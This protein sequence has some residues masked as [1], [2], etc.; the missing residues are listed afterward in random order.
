VDELLRNIDVDVIADSPAADNDRMVVA[1]TSSG[2]A[3]AMVLNNSRTAK[4]WGR[5]FELARA[6]AHLLLDQARGEAI[7]AASGPQ[8]IAGRRRRA[9]AFAAEMLL[10]TSALEEASRGVLDGVVEGHRFSELLDRF[11]VGR[12]RRLSISGTRDS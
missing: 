8:A 10:P 9:G 6:L 11:G 3:I 2:R 7:G 5:R 12:T 4:P 1:G